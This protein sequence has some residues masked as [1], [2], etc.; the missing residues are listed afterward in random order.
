MK[1][2]KPQSNCR[3][4]VLKCWPPYFAAVVSGVK[5]FELRKNDRDF[6]IGDTL[7]LREFDGNYSGREVRAKITL[8]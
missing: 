8:F 2:R 3:E 6:A 7:L 1:S 5:P 4:H